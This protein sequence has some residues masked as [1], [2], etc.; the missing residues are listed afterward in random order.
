MER[1]SVFPSR[2][3]FVETTLAA[4]ASVAAEPLISAVPGA[5][6]LAASAGEPFSVKTHDGLTLSARR[7]GDP[8]ETAIVFVHGLGQSRLVWERQTESRLAR[9]FCL[10]TYDLRG[11]GDSD[12]P[13]LAAAYEDGRRW[14]DDLDAV[15]RQAGVN[16]PTIVGWSMGGLI[17]GHYLAQH[18][19]DAIDGIN[20][21]DAVTTFDTGMLTP[22]SASFARS[23]ASEDLAVRSEAIARFLEH[24]FRQRPFP[25]VFAR[26]LVV[27]GMAPREVQL[28]VEALSTKGLDRAFQT[29]PRILLTHGLD[30]ALVYPA[31]SH[32][33]L[34]INREATVS[35]Y[36]GAGHA[37]FYEQPVRFNY[38]LAGFAE[39]R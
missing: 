9:R 29:A 31:M 23:L 14:G 15:I 16:R 32:R 3:R 17:T 12:K 35:L 36:V 2:R 34:A 13:R 25:E 21:V 38:E 5:A 8:T 6:A 33:M 27:N 30:D 20:L 26:M 37:P 28:G 7:Y 10:V 18:G 4:A 39:R 24:C 1:T 19:H 11:H 22:A